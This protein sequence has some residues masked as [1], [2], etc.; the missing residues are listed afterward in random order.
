[1]EVQMGSPGGHR[2]P[3][4][5]PQA[6]V[7]LTQHSGWSLWP[8][9]PLTQEKLQLALGHTATYTASHITHVHHS[10]SSCHHW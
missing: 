9:P 3:I 8:A 10:N 5:H 7:D 1:M 4:S 6:G 2:H